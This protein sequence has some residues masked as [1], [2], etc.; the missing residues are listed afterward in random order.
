MA[1]LQKRMAETAICGCPTPNGFRR[2]QP[3]TF[4][5]INTTWG[6]DNRTVGIRIIEGK[7]SAVRAEKRDAGADCNP[8]YLLAADIAA[9]LDGIE[10]GMEPS[11]PTLGNAYEDEGATPIPTDAE[12]AIALARDSE[13]LKGVMGENAYEIYLQ[14]AERE[15]E[16]IMAQIREVVTPVETQRYMV[17]F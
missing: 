6:P 7:D 8:Y 9:G 10:Q 12:T 13:W 17:N 3:Y 16:F 11:E 4:C 5:P 2:R 15:V 1:G 14:Q